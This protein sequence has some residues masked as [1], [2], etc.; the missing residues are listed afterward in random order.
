MQPLDEWRLP[1][2]HLGRQVLIFA[3]MDSTN[4]YAAGLGND[5]AN[6]G[7]V[8]IAHEQTAGRGQHGRTWQCP[9]GMGVLLSAL[10]F[11]PPAL[12]RPVILAALAANSVCETIRRVADLQARIKWPNDVLVRDRKVCGILIEQTGPT[13]MGIGLN[14][15]QS[16]S[17]FEE[18]GLPV[19]A[20]LE[21]FAGKSLVRDHI[22]RQLIEEL[23]SQYGQLMEGNLDKL[24]SAWKWRMGLVGKRVEVECVDQL[25]QGRLEELGFEG[26]VVRPIDGLP[27]QIQPERIKHI[28]E[29]AQT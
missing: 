11:P 21:M 28:T 8:V 4:S 3:Q 29:V 14:V 7:T 15:L 9:S 13:V 19:A 1:T 26:I 22:A 12:R 24:E 25:V 6:S 16:E 5:P 2:K 10:M 20:S 23:D 18:A 27:Q 17:T